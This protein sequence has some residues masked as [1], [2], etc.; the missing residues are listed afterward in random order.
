M[1]DGKKILGKLDR[2]KY[3]LLM[4]LIGLV[5][6]LIPGKE[7]QETTAPGKDQ[8]LQQTLACTEGIGEVRV[9]TSEYGA[10]I[11]CQGAENAKVRLDILRAVN[12]YTG[13]TSDR[14]TVLRMAD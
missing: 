2:I 8:I 11:V 7:T 3:P 9:I 10:V 4:L 12:A 6:L 5:L 14:I 1:M 13:F